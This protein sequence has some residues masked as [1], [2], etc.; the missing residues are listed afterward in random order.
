[1]ATLLVETGRASYDA[2]G[3]LRIPIARRRP[4]RLGYRLPDAS[5]RPGDHEARG[6]R[7][8]GSCG[9]DA[10]CGARAWAPTG[11]PPAVRPRRR[12]SRRVPAPGRLRRRRRPR[13]GCGSSDRTCGDRPRLRRPDGRAGSAVPGAADARLVIESAGTDR[14]SC[15]G[16]TSC[17]R[18]PHTGC[19]ARPSS[20]R[21]SVPSAHIQRVALHAR[22]AFDPAAGRRTVTDRLDDLLG[23]QRLP[24][25]R[26]HDAQR[27]R[28]EG[29][30]VDK[31]ASEELL[32]RRA[33][34]PAARR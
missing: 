31:S 30:I 2:A 25:L 21:R 34:R 24:E 10:S 33:A 4:P 5:T 20:W 18:A 32:H 16:R 11:R 19:G 27:R 1:M 13:R 29:M 14:R 22:P 6:F 3:R 17:R 9:V 28:H 7:E 12:R 23:A 8:L 26:R 15:R